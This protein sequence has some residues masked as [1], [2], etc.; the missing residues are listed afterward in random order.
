[1][2]KTYTLTFIGFLLC[3]MQ[4]EAQHNYRFQQE[5]FFGNLPY[6]KTEA[7]GG[8]DVAIGGS[9]NSIFLNPAG[10]GLI[11]D[12]EISFSTS[13]PFYALIRSDYYFAGYA[14]KVNDKL[15]LGLSLNQIAIG[16]TTF[17][18]N[19]N[20][21]F[22][23][24]DFPKSTNLTLTG[25][26]AL[27]DNLHIGLNVNRLEFK[28]FDDAPNSAAFHFDLGVLYKI[29]LKENSRL[30][31]GLSA[32]NVAGASV[33]ITAPDGMVGTPSDF[34]FVGRAAVAYI[35]NSQ[36]GVPGAGSGDFDFTATL[37]YQNV[38]NS[39]YRTTV[40]FGTEAV[41]YKA[42]AIRMGYFT[43]KVF[44]LNNALANRSRI[45][46]I[47]YGFGIIVPLKKL[48]DG[49]LPFN[50]HI[51]ITS[52]KQPSFTWRGRRLPNMRAFGL[53]LVWD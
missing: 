23:P 43:Q 21:R 31:L 41:F 50:A 1:M 44:N 13:A 22:Y 45:N 36:I 46:D 14:R 15:T 2:M 3:C 5:Y 19:I 20:G 27:T 39:D 11:G 28:Y 4:L 34:P 12:Q 24:T 53:R 47:T 29:P 30:Q 8:A 17:T 37:G 18:A 49:S 35:L 9:L 6:A 26:Y 16:P 32:A 38:L 33:K 40:R 42:L 51:D 48:T 52:Q 7:M 25:A 10:L